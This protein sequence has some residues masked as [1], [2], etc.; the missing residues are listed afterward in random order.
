MK[1]SYVPDCESGPARVRGTSLQLAPGIWLQFLIVESGAQ[2]ASS[3]LSVRFVQPTSPF[4]PVTTV[5]P[6]DAIRNS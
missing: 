6:S 5:M 2:T 1:K 3:C 4:L